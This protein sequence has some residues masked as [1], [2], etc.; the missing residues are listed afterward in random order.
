MKLGINTLED[1]SKYTRRQLV[2][3]QD[4]GWNSMIKLDKALEKTGLTLKEGSKTKRVMNPIV[5]EEFK[6]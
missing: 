4:F 5:T 3:F 6:L 2:S 1:L